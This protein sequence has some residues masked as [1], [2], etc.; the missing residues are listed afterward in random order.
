MFKVKGSIDDYDIKDFPIWSMKNGKYFLPVKAEIRKK[1]GK[2]DGDL[3]NIKLFIDDDPVVVPEEILDCLN[4]EPKALKVFLSLPDN[5][6][7]AHLKKIIST[8]NEDAR[9]LRIVEL[10]NTLLKG[11]C[12]VNFLR[13]DK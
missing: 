12:A 4:D 6:Q 10:I 7:K 11:S 8:R 13:S 5:E 3:V 9:A 1:I 2:K